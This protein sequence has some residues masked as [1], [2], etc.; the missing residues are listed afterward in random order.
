M[1]QPISRHTKVGRMLSDECARR[2]V[3]LYVISGELRIHY[4]TLSNYCSGA[5]RISHKHFLALCDYFDCEPQDLDGLSDEYL[6]T[7][8]QA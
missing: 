8:I 4:I 2:G 3:P 5:K 7:D 1:S 6:A